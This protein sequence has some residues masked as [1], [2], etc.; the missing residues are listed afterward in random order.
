MLITCLFHTKV[1]FLPKWGRLEMEIVFGWRDWKMCLIFRQFV[2]LRFFNWFFFFCITEVRDMPFQKHSS[3][4]FT[5]P[6]QAL[7]GW[8]VYS[9]LFS[10]KIPTIV[11]L[12]HFQKWHHLPMLLHPTPASSLDFCPIP[13]LHSQN[14]KITLQYDCHIPA[15]WLITSFRFTHN[16][17]SGVIFLAAV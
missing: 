9:S 15:A 11:R 4:S 6:H 1:V 8:T 3:F 7:F 16:L 14:V 13:R 12:F 17:R 10:H 2:V 5:Q